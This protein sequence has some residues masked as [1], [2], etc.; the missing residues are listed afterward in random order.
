M[1]IL[2][3]SNDFRE[4][5]KQRR[6]PRPAPRLHLAFS[7]FRCPVVAARPAV[8]RRFSWKSVIFEAASA[9]D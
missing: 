9:L 5:P 7:L 3:F 4:S 1:V 2:L 8:S 6:S